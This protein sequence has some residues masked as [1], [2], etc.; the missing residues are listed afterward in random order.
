[1]AE[2]QDVAR[3][4]NRMCDA[5]PICAG[6]EL[7][8]KNICTKSVPQWMISDSEIIEKTVMKWAAVHP[9]PVYPTWFEWLEERGIL[10]AAKSDGTETIFDTVLPTPAMFDS[11]PAD[12]A[13]AL[14]IPPK[15]G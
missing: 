10:A 12:V 1:M 5:Y 4:Y 7:Q 13:E 6:C 9:E 2:F 14:K 3:Q 8:G 11:I 15:E